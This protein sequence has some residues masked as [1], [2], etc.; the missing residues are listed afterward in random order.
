M[1]ISRW[2]AYANNAACVSERGSAGRGGRLSDASR[3]VKVIAGACA[4]R[5]G[6]IKKERTNHTNTQQ[7]GETGT[8]ASKLICKHFLWAK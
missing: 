5:A 3:A 7:Q 1:R 6:T 2:K 8:L 4:A